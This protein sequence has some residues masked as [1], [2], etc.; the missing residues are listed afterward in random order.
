MPLAKPT[1]SSPLCETKPAEREIRSKL[2]EEEEDDDDDDALLLE[3]CTSSSSVIVVLAGGDIVRLLFF[4]TLSELD[5]VVRFLVIFT[6]LFR[7]VLV[8]SI[9]RYLSR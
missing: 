6:W 9:D 8:Q 7:A 3:P 1:P 2:G 5:M 4:Q